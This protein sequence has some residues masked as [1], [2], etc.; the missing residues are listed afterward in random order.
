MLTRRQFGLGAL[1]VGALGTLHTGTARASAGHDYTSRETFDLFDRIFHESGGVGQPTD[2]NEHGGL[3]WGQSYVLAGFIRMYEAYRDTHYLDRL[4]TN[5]DLVL[6][7]RDSE[8][9]VAD[10]RGESLPAWRATH[11]YTV[12]VAALKDSSGR[13]V[14]EVRS[15]LS[16]ADLTTAT[17]RAGAAEDRFTLEVRNSRN[18]AV[19]TFTDLSMDPDSPD[20]AVRKILDAYPTPTQVTARD[21]REG[22][23]ITLPAQGATPLVSQPVI[24][25][26]HTGMIT[27]PIASFARIVLGTPKLRA[28][29]RYRAKAQ[30]YLEAAKAA[31][32]VHDREWRQS[33]DGGHLSWVKGTPLA[34]DGTEMPTNQFLAL[35]LTYAEIAAATGDPAYADRVKRMA[36][37]FA[38]ELRA[39][40][41]DA[42][43]WPYWPSFGA[44]YRGFSRDDDLSEFTPS[45]NGAQQIED[46]SHGAIDAEFAA[47]AFR[48]KLGFNGADM[49]R[50][51]RSYSRNMA[52]TDPEGVPTTFLRVDGTGGLASSGQYL[53]AP[54]WMAVAQWDQKVFEHAKS[55]YEAR[56]LEPG[57]G[58][59]LAG[60][61]YLNWQ[62]RRRR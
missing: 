16:Y 19:A 55:I 11:P 21:L 54:R 46:L 52:T 56:A 49:A 39:N 34:Y 43:H 13:P 15:S 23:E 14:L 48:H 18:D 50:F 38:R 2:N 57:Q 5:I 33:D 3:A 4:V 44:T 12:G 8:R 36:R 29:A 25:A 41:K 59:H 10:Y 53:Q 35:G 30:E 17:V 47:L 51:A 58:S 26:V 22:G 27:Y 1:A 20:Y 61:A 37:T 60:V 24:F 28:D 62:A 7:N 45:G 32:A 6:G 9:G 42:Y 40:D 31:A